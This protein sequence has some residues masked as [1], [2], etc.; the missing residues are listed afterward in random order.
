MYLA[1]MAHQGTRQRA[2]GEVLPDGTLHCYEVQPGVF[3]PVG[4]PRV[5]F[6]LSLQ[7]DRLLLEKREDTRACDD[8]AGT[9]Q[10]GPGA[11]T[12]VRWRKGPPAFPVGFLRRISIDPDKGQHPAVLEPGARR[13]DMLGNESAKVTRRLATAVLLPIGAVMCLAA[14]CDVEGLFSDNF[15]TDNL[16][17]SP[18]PNPAEG[19]V[20]VQPGDGSV[21]VVQAPPGAPAGK[22]VHIVH[23][24]TN[25]AQPVMIADLTRAAGNGTST[26]LATLFIPT[27]GP[28]P[29]EFPNFPR[30]LATV[31]FERTVV[32]GVAERLFHLDF[33]DTNELR[34]DDVPG[35]TPITFPYDKVFS[36]LVS[37]EVNGGAATAHITVTPATSATNQVDRPFQNPARAAE[38]N[39]VRFYVG[40]QF[41]ANF[42]VDDITVYDKL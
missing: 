18:S 10:L 33:M 21:T 29:A 31:E 39:A 1:A 36:I 20:R 6:L 15:E 30:A 25:T 7:A 32:P 38:L 28:R 11:L 5:S 42:F 35:S 9:W 40:G 4:S 2:F 34:M 14:N 13:M 19:H 24:H 17:A 26:L 27:P 41:L 8:D 12:F 3:R 22:W 23:N 37:N 16:G